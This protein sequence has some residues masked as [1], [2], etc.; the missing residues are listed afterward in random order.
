MFLTRS[1]ALALFVA[2]SFSF[3][4]SSMG[5]LG[6]VHL[7]WPAAPSILVSMSGGLVILGLVSR[8]AMHRVDG[9]SG[10]A[11]GRT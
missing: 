7:D 6:S 5:L 11:Q 10:V 1:P 3:L 4:T 8:I 9:E 2:W